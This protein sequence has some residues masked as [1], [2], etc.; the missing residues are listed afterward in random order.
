MVYCQNCGSPVE[1]RYC[2]KCGSATAPAAEASPSAPPPPDATLTDNIA[3]ALCYI[4]LLGIIFLLVEPYS[5]NR[6]VRFHAFQSLF[7]V[8]AMFVVNII[9]SM[10]FTMILGFWGFFSLLRL[11]FLLLWLFLLVKTYQG[12]KIILPIIG[13]LAA[14]Q[15]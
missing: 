13:P 1:G 2:A 14:K 12:D 7:L 6:T 9:V 4:P 8:A 15:A 3:G 10:M 11:A 5:R